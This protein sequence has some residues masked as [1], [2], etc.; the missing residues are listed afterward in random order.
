M[1]PRLRAAEVLL[2]AA[3]AVNAAAYA[4]DG[5]RVAAVDA[6][7]WL[8]LLLLFVMETRRPHAGAHRLLRAARLAAAVMV[9]GAALAYWHDADW[10][11]A[12]NSLL[13]FAVVLLWELQLRGPQLQQAGLLRHTARAIYAGLAVMPLAWLAI[14]AWFE[15]WDALLWLAAYTA[16]ERDVAHHAS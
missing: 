15:A 10:L 16:I 9:I 1:T 7:G 11:D 2:P 12:A 14:G 13:W 4:Y 5:D 6:C 3:L 8:V